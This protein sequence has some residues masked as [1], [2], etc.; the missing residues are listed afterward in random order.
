M[1]AG[2]YRS[3]QRPLTNLSNLFSTNHSSIRLF[4]PLAQAI[5]DSIV[6]V[7][8]SINSDYDIGQ[9]LIN[10]DINLANFIINIIFTYTSFT[11]SPNM[12]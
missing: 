5:I 8:R 1:L 2:Y 12:A 7:L 11:I 6:S 3:V 9:M 10:V 4:G